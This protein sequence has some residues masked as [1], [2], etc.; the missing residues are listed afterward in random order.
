MYQCY[1]R[2]KGTEDWRAVTFGGQPYIAA[3]L[4]GFEDMVTIMRQV[5]PTIEY[6]IRGV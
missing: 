4:A 1:A 2:Y 5:F 6:E 3:S